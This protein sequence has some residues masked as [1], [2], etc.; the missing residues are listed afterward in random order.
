MGAPEETKKRKK[1]DISHTK[2]QRKKE[3]EFSH[4]GRRRRVTEVQRDCLKK[5]VS[6]WFGV[7]CEKI[8]FM[9][10]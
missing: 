8:R 1:E 5:I 7:L 6:L 2:A 4:R 10:W 3:E 9:M